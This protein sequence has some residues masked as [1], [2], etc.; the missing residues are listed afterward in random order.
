M[1][2]LAIEKA[3]NTVTIVDSIMGSGKT[4][5]SIDYINKNKS[6]NIL[7][8][9]PFLD[10]VTRVIKATDRDFKQPINKGNGKLYAL[11][12]LLMCE[13]D[14]ASTHELFKHL[15]DDSKEHIRNGHYTLI[16][17]EVLNVIDPYNV[18]KDDL[19]ILLDSNCITIDDDGFIIW[20]K[21]KNDYDT[22]YNEIK[23]LAENRSLIIVNNKMLLWRYPPEIFKLFDSVLV[24]TYLFEASVLKS[25]FN[26]YDIPY[27]KKSI[28]CDNGKYELCDYFVASPQL[29]HLINIY[30]G[31][32]NKNIRQKD[33]GL[34][35]TWYNASINKDTIIQIQKNI[36]NYFRNVVNADKNTILWTTFK[37]Q[38]RKL[39]G[40]GYTKQFLA[41]NCRSTNEYADTYNLVYALNVYM[42]PAITQFFMH[43]GISVNQE[44]YALSEML[45][46]VWRSRIRNGKSINI[47]IPSNRMRELFSDWLHGFEHME[48]VS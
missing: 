18:K 31:K 17:D 13:E 42:H 45:Q 3:K 40:K 26:V 12:E 19:R 20:N 14:I 11:N 10:E 16:L 23:Q 32:L 34:S 6:D 4:T 29:S 30:D 43:K 5:W 39:Q 28:K 48:K 37:A 41:C 8:I 2:E 35:S 1:E 15:D 46:W 38:Q 27:K 9:T 44:L 7:Y 24:L 47:Y 36:Y 21:D 33:N 22:S 25:Y